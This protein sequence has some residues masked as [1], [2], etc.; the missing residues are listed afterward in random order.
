MTGK[1]R[2]KDWTEQP[3]GI[4]SW[5]DLAAKF[6]LHIADD[7]EA[8]A[9]EPVVSKQR[10]RDVYSAWRGDIKRSENN[11]KDNHGSRD[12]QPKIVLDHIKAAAFLTYWIRRESPIVDLKTA[13]SQYSHFGT[14][15]TFDIVLSDESSINAMADDPQ[16]TLTQQQQTFSDGR[17][18]IGS[19]CN[20]YFAF[21]FGFSMAR[22]Y[23]E[24][25]V[26]ESTEKLVQIPQPTMN[27]VWDTCYAFKFKNVSPHSIDLIYRALL[28]LGEV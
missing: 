14:D 23:H 4:T 21:T 7:C 17:Q 24:Q 12:D 18:F 1:S 6:E 28:G 3:F 27:F 22:A 2:Q 20:S 9:F 15:D 16:I 25:K 19:Y 26:L 13:Y 10:V 5:E 8:L 11:F